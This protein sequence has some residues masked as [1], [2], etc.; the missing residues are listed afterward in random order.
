MF[1]GLQAIA[2]AWRSIAH[3][4]EWT[5]LSIG[6]LATIAAVVYL[7]PRILRPALVVAIVALL[8]YF[9]VLYGDHVGRADVHRQWDDARAAAEKAQH[10]RDD[11][12]AQDLE[13][14]YGPQLAE[15]E[16]QKS[17]NAALAKQAAASKARADGYESRIVGLLANG[18][19]ASSGA[20]A[21]GAAADRLRARR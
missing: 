12:V 9:G 15:L 21:L 2:G 13:A 11:K 17:A 4:S 20:C 16:K 3:I 14:K 5:G 7:D 18:G 1:E 6:A 10:E 8:V 19:A